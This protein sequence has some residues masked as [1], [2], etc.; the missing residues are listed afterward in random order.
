M[1]TINAKNK[2][3]LII[4]DC[5]IPYMHKDMHIF[6]KAIKEKYLVDENGSMKNSLVLHIGDELDKHAIS[7]HKSD[8]DLFSA[9]HELEKSIEILHMKD[10]L[11]E[12]FPKM[13][14]CDS[15]HGSLVYRRAKAD[16]IP[17]RYYKSYQEV[18]GTKKW[19]WHDE[20]ILETKLGE[21][22]LCHG[23][24]STYGKLCKEQAMSAIQGHFHGK[25]EITW[26]SSSTR[27][28]FNMF[29]GCL[30][31]QQSMA[32]AYGK[33]STQKPI[34]GVGMLSREGY[35]KLIKMNLDKNG[36]WDKRL[37]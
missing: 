31:D 20:V 4:S 21:V 35:P 11:Y 19:S 1:K 36:R 5:H 33:N 32:F 3:V 23:K 37:P 14:L 8:V 28:R 18:L 13:H 17:L 24:T 10:G 6:L 26:H 34:L 15:N 22:Y 16:G 9:G 25:F 12:M 2:R 7:F 30:I 27:S 29:I